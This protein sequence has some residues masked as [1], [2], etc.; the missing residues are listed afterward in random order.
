MTLVLTLVSIVVG[1][2]ELD[3]D[4]ACVVIRFP[5]KPYSENRDCSGVLPRRQCAAVRCCASR[6]V[7]ADSKDP[8]E[9]AVEALKR[10]SAAC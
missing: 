2:V 5:R 9:C 8:K 10:T 3:A 6:V 4:V 1:N 7:N